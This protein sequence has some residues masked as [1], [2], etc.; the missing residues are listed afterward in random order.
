MSYKCSS[1]SKSE[2]DGCMCC[3]QRIPK[4]EYVSCDDC[5][6]EVSSY[7]LTDTEIGQLCPRCYEE[8]TGGE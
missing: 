8:Y 3:I 1:T 6:N 7:A 5:G 2:C 4:E